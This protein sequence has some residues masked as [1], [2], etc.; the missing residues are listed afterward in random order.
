MALTNEQYNSILQVY[1]ERQR[2]SRQIYDQRLEEIYLHIP[3]I[4]DID[5]EISSLSVSS[6]RL[7][8]NGDESAL[9]TLHKELQ[10][11]H[12]EKDTL[13]QKYDYPTNYLEP[14]YVCPD[15]K[16]T[17]Y[18]GNEK[19]HCF[20][21]MI[22]GFLYKQSNLRQQFENE[23][24]SHFCL[25][26]YDEDNRD[27]I[28]HVSSRD[29]AARAF[30][31][32]R[33][34]TENFSTSFSNLLLFGDVG[35]GKTFLTHCI[36]RE[37]LDQGHSVL[38]FGASAFFEVL[39]D[40]A[41]H[42]SDASSEN[43]SHILDCDLLIIDDLGTEMVNTFTVTS[44]FSILNERLLRE[45]ATV[46]STNLSPKQL[47]DQYSERIMSRISSNYQMLKMFGEDIRIRKKLLKLSVAH[48]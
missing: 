13:L 5:R 28:S 9:D 14:V 38:Y 33:Q 22:T 40:Q 45:K 31:I 41:F 7:L 26:Y 30:E 2:K 17:G 24:F 21:Q 44:L 46:I 36:A 39:S 35:T 37:L 11:L 12:E 10:A 18:I 42:R 25:D 16:D 4:Q 27:P 19:C 1:E 47:E 43:Y 29:T 3:K 20:K 6:A 34:F 32:C 23:S 48:N 8:L 15:C